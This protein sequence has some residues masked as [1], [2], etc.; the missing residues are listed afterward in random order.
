MTVLP[1]AALPHRLKSQIEH[2]PS[3]AVV[4]ARQHAPESQ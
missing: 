1:L 3:A 2:D 4:L